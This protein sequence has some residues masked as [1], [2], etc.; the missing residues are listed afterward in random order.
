MQDEK[1]K[2]IKQLEDKIKE[3]R[4]KMKGEMGDWE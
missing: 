4:D 1:N 3:M 2:I